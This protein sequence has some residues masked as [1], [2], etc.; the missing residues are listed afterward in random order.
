MRCEVAMELRPDET[1]LI[2]HWIDKDG[3]ILADYTCHRIESLI[4]ETLTQLMHDGSENHT[5]YQD[6]RDRR[7]WEL[8]YPERTIQSQGP[9][10]L[11]C[12]SSDV[13]KSKYKINVRA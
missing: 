10:T 7:Y 13:I 11:Q 1:K 9:P 12:I 2:G 5:L 4:K 8:S 6:P 3:K